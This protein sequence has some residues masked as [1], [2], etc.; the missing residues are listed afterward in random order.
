MI[1]TL[2]EAAIGYTSTSPSPSSVMDVELVAA[3]RL[4]LSPRCQ[5]VEA[6][7]TPVTKLDLRSL[8]ASSTPRPRPDS[9]RTRS[10][11][12]AIS[13]EK[14]R[15]VGMRR[16]SS[17]PAVK[18]RAH[19]SP[20]GEGEVS[21]SA[22]DQNRNRKQFSACADNEAA[23]APDNGDQLACHSPRVAV[24]L[25][26]KHAVTCLCPVGNS[27]ATALLPRDR[28]VANAAASCSI[29]MRSRPLESKNNWLQNADKT[30]N[31]SPRCAAIYPATPTGGF[32]WPARPEMTTSS[33]TTKWMRSQLENAD[34]MNDESPGYAA[35]VP[36][37]PGGQV[38]WTA[39]PEMTSSPATA[40]WSSTSSEYF[41][42]PTR[43]NMS[44]MCHPDATSSSTVVAVS[45]AVTQTPLSAHPPMTRI[46]PGLIHAEEEQ[47]AAASPTFTLLC[48]A[49]PYA[50]QL[51]AVQ[52]STAQLN[53]KIIGD[54]TAVTRVLETAASDVHVPCLHQHHLERRR[55]NHS[56]LAEPTSTV[57]PDRNV[58]TA[59]KSQV[60][61]SEMR[62]LL[63]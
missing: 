58:T 40:D 21:Q 33:T 43:A 18:W 45:D 2:N 37:T 24:P 34:K 56:V 6:I 50:A 55:L 26:A 25:R 8:E 17:D 4:L 7:L 12:A 22:R 57:A 62:L 23:A 11:T 52:P 13:V 3:D 47:M 54:M 49:Q 29:Q 9:T 28:P 19:R 10:S 44:G 30:K 39:R 31:V 53:E 27:N 14:F 5:P 63:L 51:R 41:T 61:H 15:G 38:T 48:D 32:A 36:P 59:S 20:T 16:C 1:V 46:Q 35:I 60:G 42:P